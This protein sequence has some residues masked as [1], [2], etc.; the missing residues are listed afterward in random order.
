[1]KKKDI[2]F[3]DVVTLRGPNIWTYRPVLEAWVDIGE[4][5]DF[6]SNTIPGF[7]ER[8][9]G[10]LPTLIEHR[11]SPGVRGGFLQRLREG[12]WPGHIL[13]HVTLE[14]Q[15]LAGLPG[16]F[17]KARETS[18]R[19]VYKVV[20][21]AWHEQVTRAALQEGRDLVMAAI[22]D[23]PFDVPAAV[24]RL[25]ALVDSL[26]LG[27]STACIV[28]A[29]DDR[30]IPYIRLFEGNLVQF[31][32]G[33]RQ[34]RIWTAETDRTSAIAE[35]ISRDKDLTKELLST[36]G[37]PV[38]EGRLVQSAADAWEAAQ[39]IGL[40]VV[41]K[42]YDGNH[43]RGVFTNLLTRDEI[44]SA[45]AVAVDEGSGVIVERFITGNEHRLLVVGDRMVAAAAGEPAW[46]TGDGVSTIEDL[47]GSQINTDPRRGRTENHPLN[48]VRL[49][50]AARLEIARQG[51]TATS[52]PAA[53]R[54]V[55]IQRS[56]NV[57]FDV[58]DRVHPSVAAT[59]AL[60]ARVVGLDVAGVDLVTDDISRP[61]DQTRGAIVEVNAGPG[62]LMHLKPADG[63]PRPVGRAI[64]DHLF[65]ADDDG[66]IPIVGVTGTNGKTV[67]ARLVA[68]LLH[69]S[70]KQ[71]GLACSEGLYLNKRLVQKGDCANW[72]AGRRVLMNRSV[73]AAV[74]ENDS[75]VILGQ[76][77]AYD[78]CL[79]GVVTNI[80]DGDHLGDFDINETDRLVDVFRTQIDVVLPG[81]AAV[82][83]A[84]DSRVVRMAELCDGEVLYF[85]LD[86]ALPTLAAH[87]AEG[88]RAVYLRAGRI[89]LAHGRDEEALADIAAVPLTHGGRVAFQI[90]N[91]LAAVAAAWAL[92]IPVE[93]IRA[94]IETFDID[95]ADAPWQFTLFERNGACVV[96]DDVH[97][98]S[99]LRAL[100]A[101]I[102]QFPARRRAAVYSA[103]ADR[104]DDALV[105]QGRLL[106][107]A[108][109]QVVL[110]DD[111]TVASKRP[112]GQ[113][114]S[115]LRQGLEQSARATAIAD[116]ADHA[117]AIA[118]VLDDL[119][120][121]DFALLQS[122]EAFSG[123]TI[124][125]VRRWIQQ[126]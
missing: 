120:E 15:N 43:G 111:A 55:L 118:R 37:V 50:S 97:N 46:V 9:S 82:L 49:D 74:I 44:E 85:G 117:R 110:Y 28:D 58:T 87:L 17:G 99:A 102:E 79:V 36:C 104:N 2:E 109:D 70:G 51:M 30:D 53:G 25:R 52:V 123:P 66:R 101:A 112:A 61:L 48:P 39:D 34:R 21:R 20:V 56:G 45:Y 31:G 41:V 115:L 91:V 83:N 32:Y 7:Y 100:L 84:R 6:P 107:T 124:D 10:W 35:G 42:P 93:L 59:V 11:C 27:P 88:K 33:S 71:T 13:E 81:G 98:P 80:D 114:R 76:G 60:A 73:D 62:L 54:N 4:L 22:E 72:A 92:D 14:L 65:P 69:L 57:A 94:G 23:R 77:L 119:R 38:P 106:G 121:G 5:E 78:R 47:I 16:G 8:L 90:E 96:V 125:L 105:E 86:P 3:L 116:E 19:G 24:A 68:R 108:F 126:G 75:G 64:V 18:R 95:Q 26:C 40:P 29:A 12:T 67:V 63:P 1:M 89:V 113:A 103:G 122:D